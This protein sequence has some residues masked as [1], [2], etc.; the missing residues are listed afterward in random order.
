MI[1]VEPVWWAR[2]AVGDTQVAVSHVRE[3]A[4][5]LWLPC[6]P[7][8]LCAV[9]GSATRNE[10]RRGTQGRVWSAVHVPHKHGDMMKQA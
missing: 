3:V 1:L 7:A 5:T 9:H 6:A 8:L 2:K 4:V 10:A